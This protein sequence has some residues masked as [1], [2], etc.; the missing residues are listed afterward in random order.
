M[1]NQTSRQSLDHFLHLLSH[2]LFSLYL[3]QTTVRL[4]FAKSS[5]LPE[6]HWGFS[7]EHWPD[8]RPLTSFDI[9]INRENTFESPSDRTSEWRL[10]PRKGQL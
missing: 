8:D 3:G 7:L 4:N 1:P 6:V 5:S 2:R 9:V 10:K